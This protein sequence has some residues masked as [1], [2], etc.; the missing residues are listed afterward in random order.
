MKICISCTSNLS[1]GETEFDL[2]CDGPGQVL[3]NEY[4]KTNSEFSPF[5]Y[6]FGRIFGNHIDKKTITN[7]LNKNLYSMYCS[8]RP[9][10][11][12]GRTVRP[13]F[14]NAVRPK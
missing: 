3:G 10:V 7:R 12:F 14:Y 5:L 11:G 6:Q 8:D 9:N 13:N 1:I 2:P 4:P